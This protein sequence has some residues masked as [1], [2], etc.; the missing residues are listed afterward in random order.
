ME[1]TYLKTFESWRDDAD[2]IVG[3][4]NGLEKDEDIYPSFGKKI[5]KIIFFDKE[6]DPVITVELD[7]IDM[8]GVK[9]LDDPKV[10]IDQ[11]KFNFLR[12]ITELSDNAI[13]KIIKR[14]IESKLGGKEIK[15][16]LLSF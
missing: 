10:Y 6:M 14:Y 1:K 3:Y 5:R 12:E 7:R 11:E 2:T 13:K 16:I 4:L 15:D 9:P 8:G